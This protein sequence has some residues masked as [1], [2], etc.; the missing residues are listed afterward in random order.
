MLKGDASSA[1][2]ISAIEGLIFPLSASCREALE[3]DG[4][5][6]VRNPPSLPPKHANGHALASAVAQALSLPFSCCSI[7]PVPSHSSGRRLSSRCLNLR[8]LLDFPA[9][10]PRCCGVTHT[11]PVS[12]TR[13][14][15]GRG[16]LLH[17]HDGL[18][19]P[20]PPPLANA[21]TQ[22]Y[23][24]ALQKH[25]ATVL[26]PG[27][28]LFPDGGWKLSSTSDN[29]W[30]SKIYLSQFIAHQVG[31]PQCFSPQYA[32]QRLFCASPAATCFSDAQRTRN[33]PAHAPSSLRLSSY[34]L[35]PPPLVPRQILGLPRDA[36]AKAAD[37]AHAGWL[38]HGRESYWGWSDQMVAGEAKGAPALAPAP[39]RGFFGTWRQRYS[40]DSQQGLHGRQLMLYVRPSV[41]RVALLPP[42]RHV[43]PVAR[44]GAAA[45]GGGAP[46]EGKK[47]QPGAER[48][49]DVIRSGQS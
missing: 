24:H 38:L 35:P 43:H 49:H 21:R 30:L 4:R 29:S 6:E 9:L 46:P 23:L 48:S 32:S 19:D 7:A 31:K 15:C 18:S 16:Q 8:A 34:F 47:E 5:F 41:C 13:K 44:D 26:Q 39:G 42:W 14:L 11:L 25:L 20:R 22:K 10:T 1:K 2:T 3:P 37:E 17:S 45:V 33:R 40:E 28:C 36:A 27:A 12:R